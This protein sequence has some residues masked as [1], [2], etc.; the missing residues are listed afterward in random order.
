ME[1]IEKNFGWLKALCQFTRCEYSKNPYDLLAMNGFFAKL[2][3]KSLYA[4]GLLM[5]LMPIVVLQLVVGTLIIQRYFVGVTAQLS[6][7]MIERIEYTHQRSPQ[8][9]E[10]LQELERQ[11]VQPVEPI[12]GDNFGLFEVTGRLIRSHFE[13]HFGAPVYVD[14]ETWRFVTVE[15]PFENQRLSLKFMRT[16]LA[17]INPHQILLNTTGF[18]IIMTILSLLFLRNQTRSLNRLSR[19]AKAFGRGE[20]IEYTPTGSLEV[21]SAGRS[22]V[23]MRNRIS[24][25]REQRNLL[26]SGVSHDLRTPITRLRLAVELLEAEAGKQDMLE[27]IKVLEGLSESFLNYATNDSRE[28]FETQ[29]L[30]DAIEEISSKYENTQVTSLPDCEIRIRPLLFRRAIENLLSNA[31]RYGT[32][33][34]IS[35][36]R[37]SWSTQIN[38]DDNGEGIAPHLRAEALKA[39]TRLDGARTPGS[40]HAGLGLAIA[41]DAIRQH[42][43]ELSLDESEMGG[44]RAQITLPNKLDDI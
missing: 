15:F 30:R 3:P 9:D 25:Q 32:I 17:P 8:I 43:G 31:Q 24:R 33:T 42:G 41:A 22:F 5:I 19:A 16:S 37:D 4:R 38:I 40:G 28:A 35:G 29:W 14:N 11:G 1:K 23:A 12:G 36:T 2:A 44:L 21:R 20:E 39:Y 18:A 7:Q 13:D 27:D 6:K 26:L 10:F 34:V